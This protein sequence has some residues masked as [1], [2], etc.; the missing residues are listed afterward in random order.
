MFYTTTPTYLNETEFLEHFY[1]G[2][3][4]INGPHPSS[5]TLNTPFRLLFVSMNNNALEDTFTTTYID[6]KCSMYARSSVNEVAPQLA[7]AKL[8]KHDFYEFMFVLGGEI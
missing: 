4:N 1:P 6:S 3:H 8:H 5:Y 7:K 2:Y